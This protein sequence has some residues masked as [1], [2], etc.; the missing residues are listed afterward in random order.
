MKICRSCAH[1]VSGPACE[2]CGGERIVAHPELD[3]LTIAHIDCDAF[4]AAIEK[5]DDP[6]L[7][8]RPVIV[9]GGKRGVVST[10][11]YLARAYGVRSAM[12]MFKALELCPDAVVIRPDMDRYIEE[13]RIVR[14]MM[15]A[16]TP[17]VE[18]ISIDEAFLDLAGTDELHGAFPAQTL[19]RLQTRIEEER[20]LTVSVGLSFNKFLAKTASDL[21]KPRGFS[22]IGRAEALDFLAPRSVSTLPGVGPAGA[23]ALARHGWRTIGGLRAAGEG[24]LVKALGDWGKRLHALSIAEDA[25]KVDPDGERK[26]ISAETT[27]L[28]DIGALAELEDVLWPLC[29]KVAVRA[30]SADLA[31][32][33][34]TLKLR[35]ARFR[36]RTRRLQFTEPT[37]LAHRI[38][39]AARRLLG[40]EVDGRVSFRLIGVGLSDF[41]PAADADKGDLLDARTP[42]IAA[43][44]AAMARARNRFGDD[45][46]VT[47][48]GLKGR[49]EE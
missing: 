42:R 18:P 27:F 49:Q 6:S 31:G 44:E 20:R 4:Y 9:G 43:A 40:A 45:A 39:E 16:L 25:R 23:Q 24:A 7:A 17:L 2:G 12:P 37:L 13:G 46:I 30:R 36:T 14:A 41:S 38:F 33:T 19:A 10:A 15:Q 3:A 47:G 5:R 28:E 11:C 35:D 26:S 32:R 48:R 8:A 34:L 22:A 21:D 1:L 29:E